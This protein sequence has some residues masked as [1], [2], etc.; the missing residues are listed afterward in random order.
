MRVNCASD[1]RHVGGGLTATLVEE[2]LPTVIPLQRSWIFP[3]WDTVLDEVG[4]LSFKGQLQPAPLP[5]GTSRLVNTLISP[6]VER[7]TRIISSTTRNLRREVKEKRFRTRPFLPAGGGD[8]EVPPCAI[9]MDDLL[10]IANHLA[11][12]LQRRISAF[13]TG[14]FPTK[15]IER[16]HAYGWP[17]NIREL[18]NFVCRYVIL[19]SDDRVLRRARLQ[20]RKS[21][22]APGTLTSGETRLREVTRRTLA[23]VER[24]MIVTGSRTPQRQ[25]QAGRQELL[26]SAIA[27]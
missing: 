20:W 25:P 24:E 18:E 11:R 10:V 21:A 16:M 23:N 4:E 27:R 14:P 7:R 6:V 5:S 1:F 17:G 15:L 12:S 3:L 2:N 8:L 13:P 26:A 22:T 19:G 9:D